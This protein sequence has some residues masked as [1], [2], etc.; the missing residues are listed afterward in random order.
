[1]ERSTDANWWQFA[2]DPEQ[3]GEKITASAAGLPEVNPHH[4]HRPR[5]VDE[6]T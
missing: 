4:P 5:L 3:R 2:I 1:M 6:T